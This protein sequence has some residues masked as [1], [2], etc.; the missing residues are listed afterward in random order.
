MSLRQN[1]TWTAPEDKDSS[2]AMNVDGATPVLSRDL[3]SIQA[4][5]ANDGLCDAAKVAERQR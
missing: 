2:N 3:G 5:L 4:K 1:R